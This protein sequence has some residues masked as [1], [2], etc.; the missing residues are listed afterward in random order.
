MKRGI[1]GSAGMA[2]ITMWHSIAEAAVG[3][4]VIEA[5]VHGSMAMVN[6][7]PLT[8][9][10]STQAIQ[11]TVKETAMYSTV[12]LLTTTAAIIATAA[13]G[14]SAR[15][16][17]A[18]SAVNQMSF[19]PLAVVTN[20]NAD[21]YGIQLADSDDPTAQ[22]VA[23]VSPQKADAK[24]AKTKS[25][26]GDDKEKSVLIVKYGDG[27]PDG[28]K[29]IAGTG[30]VIKFTLPDESQK[31]RG[32]K[33][34]C[35]RYG[36]PK[37]PN[38]NIKITIVSDDGK[39]VVHTKM[40]PYTIFK[41]GE[42]QWTTIRFKKETKVPKTI[43]AILEFKATRTKGVFVSYD[44]STEGKY[45]KIGVPGGTFTDAEFKGDWIIQAMLT[46]PE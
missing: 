40:V 37:A 12:Q 27:K 19:P 43:R 21:L 17:V 45:S 33:I 10:C 3:P 7:T 16:S 44:T 36:Y 23:F 1:E 11:L 9:V 28:K 32:L 4:S 46:K 35:A 38:E 5:T 6:G 18:E 29:S 13:L 15:A 8:P 31:L 24:S 39:K 25:A 41:R 26:D 2:A 34:H 20:Q 14:W 30:K 22:A 42:S